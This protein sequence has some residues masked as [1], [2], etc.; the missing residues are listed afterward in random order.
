MCDLENQRYSFDDQCSGSQTLVSRPSTGAGLSTKSFLLAMVSAVAMISQMLIT[1][2][3]MRLRCKIFR[4]ICKI[5]SR[6][7]FSIPS[8]GLIFSSGFLFERNDDKFVSVTQ[9]D[10]TATLGVN[11]NMWNVVAVC[12]QTIL[13]KYMASCS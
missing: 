13:N 9:H 2:C 12:N 10:C 5:Q 8:P 4:L 3:D 6:Y 1:C 7:Y 11:S